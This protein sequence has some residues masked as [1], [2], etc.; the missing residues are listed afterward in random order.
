MLLA[1]EHALFETLL[2]KGWILLVKI[3][4]WL[5][6]ECSVDASIAIIHTTLKKYDWTCKSLELISVVHFTEAQKLYKH[7]M[8][9]Y[10]AE[11]LVFLDETIVNK[12]TSF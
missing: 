1:D 12:L 7:H 5:S 4:Y 8:L 11:D 2:E 9:E 10:S 3:K 6:V